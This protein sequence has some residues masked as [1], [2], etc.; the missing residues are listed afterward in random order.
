MKRIV[1]FAAFVLIA[2]GVYVAP[3]THSQ[4]RV[5]PAV[6][7]QNA[8]DTPI[9]RVYAK[10]SK[11]NKWGTP[12]PNTEIPAES[13]VS[14]NLPVDVACT[15]DIRFEFMAGRREDHNNVDICSPAHIVVGTPAKK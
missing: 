3:T 1:K 14:I 15:Y 2:A 6:E 4:T 8:S 9:L 7:V 12:L 13:T 5:A 11:S 10:I